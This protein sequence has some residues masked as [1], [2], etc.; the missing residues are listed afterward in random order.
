[1]NDCRNIVSCEMVLMYS[2]SPGAVTLVCGEDQKSA[3]M[4]AAQPDGPS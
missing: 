4:F 1:M 3:E 2:R